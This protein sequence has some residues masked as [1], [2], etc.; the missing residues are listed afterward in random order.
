[1]LFL[2]ANG[3][4]SPALNNPQNVPIEEQDADIIPT[5]AHSNS[6]VP[7]NQKDMTELYP[8][9]KDV[10]S[11][12]PGPIIIFSV[13]RIRDNIGPSLDEGGH[14]TNRDVDKAETFNIF[15]ASVFNT[16]DG[17]WDPWD[18]VL[19]D[20]DWGMINSHLTLN[21]FKTCCCSWMHINLWSLMGFIPGY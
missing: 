10:W 12:A 3:S 17:P 1:M 19:E 4:R 6:S 21:L 8:I 13:L 20:H 2:A 14:L 5:A 11:E 15:I 7:T 9:Q 18:P 16:D